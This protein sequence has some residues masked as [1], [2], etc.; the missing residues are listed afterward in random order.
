MPDLHRLLV[1]EAFQFLPADT[2][3]LHRTVHAEFF[4]EGDKAGLF[5]FLDCLGEVIHAVVD[6]VCVFESL[7]HGAVHNELVIMVIDC[8]A[9]G[10]G[11]FLVREA[12]L[13]RDLSCQIRALVRMVI[14]NLKPAK[15]AGLVSEGLILCAE[16]PDGSLALMVPEAGKNV[17]AGS[18]IG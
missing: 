3:S 14:T 12:E 5:F 1:R 16:A 17:P 7:I 13:S 10:I 9:D 4:T 8:G 2:G 18:E 6:H 15:L 11:L